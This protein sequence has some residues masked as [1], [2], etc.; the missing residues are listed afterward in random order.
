MKKQEIKA[1]LLS[2]IWWQRQWV[3]CSRYA[4]YLMLAVASAGAAAWIGFLIGWLTGASRSP[5]VH[6]VAPLVFGLLAA[7]GV[8]TTLHRQLRSRRAVCRAVFIA[9]LAWV[10]CY[11]CFFGVKRGNISRIGPYS[12]FSTL[13]DGSWTKANGTTKAILYRFRQQAITTNVL[14]SDFEPII[15]DVVKPLLDDQTNQSQRVLDALMIVEPTL[16]VD[17]NINLTAEANKVESTT[18][19]TGPALGPVESDSAIPPASQSNRPPK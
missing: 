12:S 8:G 17:G 10:F 19:A 7:I 16:V 15:Q 14:Y 5:V 13:L 2:Q 18:E 1:K 6:A 11:C 9:L 4:L 3:K